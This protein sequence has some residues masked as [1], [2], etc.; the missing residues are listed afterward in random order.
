MWHDTRRTPSNRPQKLLGIW[1][2]N[3][4]SRW[5]AVARCSTNTRRLI[6]PLPRP[7]EEEIE[8]CHGVALCI[9]ADNDNR[10]VPEFASTL[11]ITTI[12]AYLD[13]DFLSVKCTSLTTNYTLQCT[14]IPPRGTPC[15]FA[16]S[17]LTVRFDATITTERPGSALAVLVLSQYEPDFPA[18]PVFCSYRWMIVQ[19]RN[20]TSTVTT[21]PTLCDRI[22]IFT[23]R[24]HMENTSGSPMFRLMENNK[25][26][27]GTFYVQQC[28]SPGS[29]KM[30]FANDDVSTRVL[31]PRRRAK[32]LSHWS[33]LQP[34]LDHKF[35]G[36]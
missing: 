13:W 18:S 19:P 30:L 10:I 25:D 6:L 22:E 5:D 20:L 1:F 7:G 21:D 33:D 16:M 29:W 4:I 32:R 3:K 24:G 31:V 9:Q 28:Q 23:R 14:L 2:D 36:R 34:H 8:S 27:K 11:S 17:D 12:W 35:I 15:M 26:L